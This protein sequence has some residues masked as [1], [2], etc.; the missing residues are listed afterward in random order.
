MMAVFRNYPLTL[1][2]I[3][4]RLQPAR[5]TMRDVCAIVTERW[6][7]LRWT[8]R[9]QVRSSP[10]E[11]AAAYGEVVWSWR[12]D[13]GA[14]SA[15]AFP[16][17][18]GARKAASPGRARISR[19]TIAR[20]KPGCLGCTCGL[21]RVLFCRT[22]RTRDCGRSRRPAFPAPFSREGQRDCITRAR[23]RRGN[24]NVCFCR[25]CE[26][27]TLLRLLHRLRWLKS[28]EAPRKSTASA[29]IA[30]L[31]FELP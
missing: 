12:R 4:T 22:L 13:P 24:E 28:A 27:T 21:T 10:D 7:G 5:A 3:G 1:P 8:L 6:R 2:K 16:P 30:L 9:R 29:I 19:K 26:R 25:H 11:S 23:S 17:A 31:N 14:T 18:T 15:G 20:G